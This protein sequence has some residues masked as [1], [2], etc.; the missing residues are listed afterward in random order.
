[1]K[2]PA[3]IA[4]LLLA[5]ATVHAAPDLI[6]TNY[7]ANYEAT[8]AAFTNAGDTGLSTGTVYACIPVATVTEWTAAGVHETNA[9][10]DVRV[11]VFG[12]LSH[13]YDEIQAI[14]STNRP[15][16]MTIS[17]SFA[18]ESSTNA[19]IKI[20]HNVMTKQSVSTFTIPSE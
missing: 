15:T 6:I 16:Q 10:S 1:M 19:D 18:V 13:L 9:T 12:L 14:T 2:K 3:I 8:P 7:I 17:E 11:F 4:L 5:A 20:I